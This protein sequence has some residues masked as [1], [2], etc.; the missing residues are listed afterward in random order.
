MA[1]GGAGAYRKGHRA[2]LIVKSIL[3]RHGFHVQ[4]S[5]ASK[6]PY[7]LLALTPLT[8]SPVFIEVKGWS[9]TITPRERTLLVALAK[10]YCALPVYAHYE[11]GDVYAWVVTAKGKERP[12][13]PYSHE[14]EE[15]AWA[16]APCD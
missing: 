1:S 14:E 7:D 8:G 6:G 5:Y 15:G 9:A 11:G 13:H 2:E 12:W 10:G 16:D 4:R 3:E